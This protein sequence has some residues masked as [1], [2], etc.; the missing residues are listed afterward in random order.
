MSTVGQIERAT[1]NRVVKLLREQLGYTY[2]GNWEVRQDNSNIEE[3]YLRSFLK[4]QGYNDALISKA[5][6]ELNKV[7]G[8]Q[9]KSLY[10]INKAVYD[11]LRY[12][13]KVRPDVGEN[14]E[15][16]GL[17][18]WKDPLNNDFAVAE[19]VTVEG[20]HTKRPDVVLYV[21]GLALGV[22]ELK[23]SVVSVSEGIR[24]KLD[25]QKKM[26]IQPF[27]MTMQ[28]IMAG[29]DTEGLRYGVIETAEKYYLTWKEESAIENLLDRALSQLC[30]KQRFLEIIHD[31]IVFDSGVKKVCRHNQYFGVRAAQERVRRREGGIIWNTQGS[32]KSL[33]M[34]WLARWIRENVRD[35]RVL[36]I[37]DRT[38]LDEQI[39]KVFKGV[40]EEVYRTKSGADL[41]AKLNATTPW[42][43]CSLIHKFGGKEDGEE[44]GDIAGYVEDVRKALP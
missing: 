2:L 10:D 15:T 34:V 38:E 16:V 36:I 17:I 41:I 29:N 31:F 1:Q 14:T 9:S 42:L 11:L 28:L 32:G 19:E 3:R 30:A 27:F 4:R 39:E 18:D 20:E 8:D 40:N 12:G 21:N 37:T 25:N 43:I 26:F 7:A 5:L 22:L 35:A 33:T 13:V 44:V 24:Q 23:R 6:Y